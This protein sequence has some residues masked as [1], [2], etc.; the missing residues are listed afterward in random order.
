MSCTMDERRSR[1]IRCLWLRRILWTGLDWHFSRSGG[2]TLP[3][4]PDTRHAQSSKVQAVRANSGQSHSRRVGRMYRH[5][6]V[7]ESSEQTHVRV[8]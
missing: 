2:L 1:A 5:A 6:C 7:G 8:T 4:T 3:K